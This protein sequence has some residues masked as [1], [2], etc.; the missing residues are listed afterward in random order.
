MSKIYSLLL[1]T[2]VI[3]TSCKPDEPTPKP[4]TSNRTVLV[5]MSA[6]NNLYSNAIDDINEMEKGWDESFNGKMIVY[7]SPRSNSIPARLYEIKKGTTS[8][9][10]SRII[11]EYGINHDDCNPQVMAQIIADTRSLAKADSYGV[12]F[13]SHSTGWLPSNMPPV[14][15]LQIESTTPPVNYSFGYNE[16][17]KTLMEVYDIAKALPSDVVFDFIAFDACHMAS[18]E[19]SYQLRKNAKYIVA[20]AAET[21]AQGF[22]YDLILADLFAAPQADLVSLINHTFEYF[23]ALTNWEQTCTLS[24]TD[25]SKLEAVATSLRDVVTNSPVINQPNLQQIQQ[26][27]RHETGLNNVIFDLEDFISY[28]WS[29]SAALPQFRTTL[30]KAIIH[31]VNTKTALIKINIRTFCGATSYIPLRSKPETL[32]AY[33]SKFDWSKASGLDQIEF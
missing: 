25:C 19:S 7:L 18:I 8:E 10:E 17:Y 21:P 23:N 29:N 11:K 12:I 20:S 4:K 24:L 22:K 27:G 13:W 1:L 14:K 30:S 32:N 31:K 9:I 3:L 5:Y 15:S 33:R 26:F 2:I 16:R 28:C 6:N